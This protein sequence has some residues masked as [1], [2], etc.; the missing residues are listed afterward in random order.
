MNARHRSDADASDMLDIRFTTKNVTD[1]EIAAVT[2]VISAAVREQADDLAEPTPAP[3]AWARSQ[4]VLRAPIVP[5]P[6][7]W[8]SFNAD[9]G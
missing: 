2:A 1:T 4:R 7:A 8:R 3:S 5:A 9:R 6:G